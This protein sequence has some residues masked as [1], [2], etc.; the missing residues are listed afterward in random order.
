MPDSRAD[1]EPPST[2][3]STATA[4]LRQQASAFRLQ[5]LFEP[6]G[7]DL[8]DDIDEPFLQQCCS[9]ALRAQTLLTLESQTRVELSLQML[10]EPAMRSLNHQ[11]RDK[12]KSTNVLSFASG[13]PLMAASDGEA[14]DG[15]GDS[16]LILGDLVLCPEVVSREA[17][18]QGKP[19]LDHWAHMLVHGCLHLC[20]HDHEEP[21]QAALMEGTET[22]IL[23]AMGIPD[24]YAVENALDGQ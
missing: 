15:Q 9:A 13:M 7:C 14:G 10:D 11:Y 4:A 6:G 20:G 3:G 16:L 19:E 17:K 21:A 23:S 18:Q 1:S 12:D 2:S 8:P 5:L 22:R 24:P